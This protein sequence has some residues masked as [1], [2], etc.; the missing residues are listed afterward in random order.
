MFIIIIFW[1]WGGG[2]RITYSTRAQ[3]YL[4]L[5]LAIDRYVLPSVPV[6]ADTDINSENVCRGNT[7]T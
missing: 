3:R 2:V 1:E 5:D 6:D 7:D 4:H